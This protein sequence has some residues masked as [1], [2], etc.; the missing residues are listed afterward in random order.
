MQSDESA[1]EAPDGLICREMAIF[2]IIAL[3]SR[4]R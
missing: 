1:P 3:D 4:P 2:S